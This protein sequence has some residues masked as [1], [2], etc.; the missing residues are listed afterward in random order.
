M[1][2]NLYIFTDADHQHQ[3][4]IYCGSVSF[5]NTLWDCRSVLTKLAPFSS[6]PRGS[7]SG[8]GWGLMATPSHPTRKNVGHRAETARG[9]H[10]VG[11]GGQTTVKAKAWNHC[12]L[13]LLSLYQDG[14][15]EVPPLTVGVPQ[16]SPASSQRS[17]AG[18]E[19]NGPKPHGLETGFRGHRNSG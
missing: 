15:P 14:R 17:S 13:S 10:S 18:G 1:C 16:A 2:C 8:S 12:E 9:G 6:G 4:C 3:Q 19:G 11:D 5:V 7:G